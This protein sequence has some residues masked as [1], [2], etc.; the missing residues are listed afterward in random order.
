MNKKGN[1]RSQYNQEYAKLLS[2]YVNIQLIFDYTQI[3]VKFA[4]KIAEA[5]KP[6]DILEKKR[7]YQL[8]LNLSKIYETRELI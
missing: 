3:L 7:R 8:N 1:F 5:C 4:K 2:K 6:T